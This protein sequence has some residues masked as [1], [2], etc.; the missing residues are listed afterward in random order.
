MSL[1]TLVI[2]AQSPTAADVT[3]FAAAQGIAVTGTLDTGLV[4]AGAAGT[5]LVVLDPPLRVD[6]EEADR[7]LAEPRRRRYGA[8]WWVELHAPGGDDAGAALLDLLA[9]FLAARRGGEIPAA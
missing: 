8:V 4:L 6:G 1:D 5:P 2:A 7:M 3:D 9:Q